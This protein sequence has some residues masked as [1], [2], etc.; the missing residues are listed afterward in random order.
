MVEKKSG[1]CGVFIGTDETGY[2]YIVG[3]RGGD[4]RVMNA[5]LK[6]RFNARGGGQAAMV[7]GSVTCTG[8]EVRAL[9][10]ETGE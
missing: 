1:Y 9:F 6:E 5:L 4:A 8:D 10:E 7:Q 3:R 2:R